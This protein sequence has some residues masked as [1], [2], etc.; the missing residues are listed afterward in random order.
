MS[1]SQGPEGLVT[2]SRLAYGLLLGHLGQTSSQLLPLSRAVA[3]L[4]AWTNALVA[5]FRDCVFPF[6][7]AMRLGHTSSC[8]RDPIDIFLPV[9]DTA[10]SALT[11]GRQDLVD[12]TPE[13]WHDAVAAVVRQATAAI[14][15]EIRAPLSSSSAA[16]PSLSRQSVV[17]HSVAAVESAESSPRSATRSP[18]SEDSHLLGWRERADSFQRHALEEF[19]TAMRETASVAAGTTSERGSGRCTSEDLVAEDPLEDF[20]YCCVCRALFGLGRDPSLAAAHALK[21]QQRRQRSL[22]SAPAASQ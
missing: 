18:S 4:D 20:A 10:K 16:A 19:T 17:N 7:K 11:D 13:Q 8:I 12:I 21:R 1:L 3:A 15:Q 2:T 9:V 14:V 5:S 22:H 6:A